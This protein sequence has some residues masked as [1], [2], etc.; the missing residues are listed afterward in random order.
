MGKANGLGRLDSCLCNARSVLYVKADINEVGSVLIHGR[1]GYG[2]TLIA[3]AI[4]ERLSR[5]KKW[6]ARMLSTSF[7]IRLVEVR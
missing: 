7:F 6:F 1:K 2:K 4:A 5:E 3:R